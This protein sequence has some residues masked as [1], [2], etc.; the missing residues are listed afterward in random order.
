MKNALKWLFTHEP[1]LIAGV[2]AGLA[3][4]LGVLYGD[5]TSN[6]WSGTLGTL[7]FTAFGMLRGF[8]TSP[9]TKAALANAPTQVVPMASDAS[10]LSQFVGELIH[11]PGGLPALLES[12]LAQ[13]T[14]ALED[15]K[16]RILAVVHDKP[17]AAVPEP[18]AIEPAPGAVTSG[19]TVPEPVPQDVPVDIPP[20]VPQ[21]VPEPEDPELTKLKQL[22]GAP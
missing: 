13:F 2:A 14:Q 16:T 1:A 10:Y 11:H 5:H 19:E 18:P 15:F 7:V 20:D 9:A 12:H 22:I 8:V 4:A 21:D 17:A 6:A 3:V